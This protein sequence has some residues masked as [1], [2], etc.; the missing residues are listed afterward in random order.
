MQIAL[1]WFYRGDSATYFHNGRIAGFSTFASF[2]PAGDIAAVILLNHGRF[3][4]T[5]AID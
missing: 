5:L 4:S 3:S 1:A 2:N